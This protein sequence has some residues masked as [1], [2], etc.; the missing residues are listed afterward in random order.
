MKFA[1]ILLISL[2]AQAADLSKGLICM[3][4]TLAEGVEAKSGRFFL[5]V[6]TKRD[7]EPLLLARWSGD[8][9]MTYGRGMA[10]GEAI[11]QG[12]ACKASSTT[13][14]DGD[15]YFRQFCGEPFRHIGGPYYQVDGGLSLTKNGTE[16]RLSCVLREKDSVSARKAITIDLTDC[17]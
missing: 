11:P 3:G 7:G 12:L 8:R 10:C 1:L 16:G 13:M 4:K 9:G 2:N 17:Q 6:E 14:S 5:A 15:F